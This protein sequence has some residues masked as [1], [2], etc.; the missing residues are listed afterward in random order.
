M[1]RRSTAEWRGL[2]RH[3]N[4]RVSRTR[5]YR[6]LL[7]LVK[8]IVQK[9]FFLNFPS[10]DGQGCGVCSLAF[11]LV[12]LCWRSICDCISKA[13][14]QAKQHWTKNH[15]SWSCQL[16]EIGCRSFAEANRRHPRGNGPVSLASVY[17]LALR[18]PAPTHSVVVPGWR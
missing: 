11:S 13:D 7:R 9:P 3:F 14:T 12:P 18:Q 5:S 6:P 1:H 17:H 15:C 4:F 2:R 8:S 16:S 10:V